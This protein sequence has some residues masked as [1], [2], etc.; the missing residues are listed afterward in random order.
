MDIITAVYIGCLVFGGGLLLITVL[1][2]DILGGLLDLDLGGVSFFP[3]AY[4]F[5]A[6]FG[7]GGLIGQISLGMDG[8]QSAMLALGAGLA[9]SLLVFV[10]F[11]LLIH[12]EAPQPASLQDLVGTVAAVDV[13][14]PAGRVGTVFVTFGGAPQRQAATSGSAA[15]AGQMVRVVGV[16]GT[17]LVVEPVIQTATPADNA[18]RT[19]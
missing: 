13:A 17:T 18:E 14:I 7:V 11:R 2:D 5:V 16:A 6:M 10:M 19:E 9:G 1:L 15:A 8:P 4:G 12:S 3:L